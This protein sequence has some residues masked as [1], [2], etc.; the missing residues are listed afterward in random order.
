MFD[1]IPRGFNCIALAASEGTRA[2]F[3]NAQVRHA[4]GAQTWRYLYNTP[5]FSPPTERAGTEELQRS[6]D[7]VVRV[8]WRI[9]LNYNFD[10]RE[11]G[12]QIKIT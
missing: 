4:G 12:S 11:A 10:S 6:F 1:V 8:T 5:R 3:W 2:V 7:I 9:N